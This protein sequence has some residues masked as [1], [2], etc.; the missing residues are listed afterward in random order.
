MRPSF[1]SFSSSFCSTACTR[2]P[3][4]GSAAARM[5][6][7]DHFK[8]TRCARVSLAARTPITSSRLSSL[9]Q[10]LIPR[11]RERSD[12]SSNL[13]FRALPCAFL[14]CFIHTPRRQ[15]ELLPDWRQTNKAR[16]SGRHRCSCCSW[17]SQAERKTR[18]RAPTRRGPDPDTDDG[19]ARFSSSSRLVS[20]LPRYHARP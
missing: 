14:P 11:E 12:F 6:K 13:A 19:D 9:S 3:S 1:T 8:E 17:R 4:E 18:S 5:Q 10:S 15:S 20:C 7:R 16:G 2:T